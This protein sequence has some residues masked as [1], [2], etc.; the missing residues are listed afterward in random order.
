MQFKCLAVAFLCVRQLFGLG[1]D[2]PQIVISKNRRG[3]EGDELLEI[4]DGLLEISPLEMERPEI[5][6]GLLIFGI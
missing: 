5:E 6:E 4:F 3:I 1:L 2:P